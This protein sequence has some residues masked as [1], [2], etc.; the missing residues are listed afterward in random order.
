MYG[1]VQLL[2]I[3]YIMKGVA[4]M[5]KKK[6]GV[7]LLVCCLLTMWTMPVLA[8]ETTVEKTTE[9]QAEKE[10]NVYDSNGNLISIDTKQTKASC[11]HIP[12]NHV[13]D[14]V[15]QHV[16]TGMR[17]DVYTANATWCKCCNTI[18]KMNSGWTYS[19]TH[20]GCTM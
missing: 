7:F 1:W 17:C 11:T 14:T 13:T 9:Y 6:M 18:L 15:W 16:H 8:A 10:G 2:Q 19:Y 4:T 3:T 12:C 20:Y 5:C